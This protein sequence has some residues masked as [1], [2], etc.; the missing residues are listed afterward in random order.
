MLHARNA[1]SLLFRVS[2]LVAVSRDRTVEAF[3]VAGFCLNCE[4]SETNRR[5]PETKCE[6]DQRGSCES[7]GSMLA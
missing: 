3:C 5:S 2:M 6:T 4:Q 7:G 1:P